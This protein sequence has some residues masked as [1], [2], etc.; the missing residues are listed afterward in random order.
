[1]IGQVGLAGIAYFALMMIERANKE[2]LK[3]EEE[4]GKQ[5]DFLLNRV[6]TTLEKNSELNSALLHS[7]NGLSDRILFVEKAKDAKE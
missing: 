1:L 6:L 4:I 2:G 7:V 3:R 5:L